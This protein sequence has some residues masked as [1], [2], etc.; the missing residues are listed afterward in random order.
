MD[1]LEI[2]TGFLVGGM[3]VTQTFDLSESGH[4][5]LNREALAL[6]FGIVLHPGW[7][8]GARTDQAHVAL[9]DIPQLRQLGETQAIQD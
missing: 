7:I 9:H 8:F 2:V 6:P 3:I 1:V 4:S 5:W